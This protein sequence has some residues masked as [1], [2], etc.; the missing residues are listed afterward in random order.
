MTNEHYIAI[1]N[2]LAQ[3]IKGTEWE[4]QVYLVGGCVRDKIMGHEIHDIDIAVTKPNGGIRFA[5]WLNKRHLTAKGRK[6]I[7]FEHFGTAKFRLKAYPGF[8]IDCVQTRKG[9]YVY[10][11][12]PKPYENFGTIEEDALC[13]DLTINSLFVNITTGKLLDPTGRGLSDIKHHVIRTPNDPDVSLRDNA[14]HI[15]RCIRFAVKYG[16]ALSPELIEAMKCN[17]DIVTEATTRRMTKE[18][19][20]ILHLQDKEKAFALIEE[21]GIMDFVKPYIELTEHLIEEKRMMRKKKYGHRKS[22]DKPTDKKKNHAPDKRVHRKKH[23][24]D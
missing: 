11:E 4:G 20:S 18:L 10:E 8:E 2:T 13:R 19:T 24:R 14:M 17:I 15:L 3:I 7:L 22:S 21:I 9:R 5:V 23:R 6:P 12:E 1:T 16:W